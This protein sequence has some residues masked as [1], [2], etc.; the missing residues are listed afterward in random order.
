[1]TTC[2]VSTRLPVSQ[3][4][5]SSPPPA[6]RARRWPRSRRARHPRI[7]RHGQQPLGCLPGRREGGDHGRSGAQPWLADQLQRLISAGHSLDHGWVDWARARR[8]ARQ[9]LGNCATGSPLPSRSSPTPTP[10]SGSRSGGSTSPASSSPKP[11]RRSRQH[12]LSVMRRGVSGTQP[13]KPTTGPVPPVDRL[14]RQ[15]SEL[16]ERLDRMPHLT[17]RPASGSHDLMRPC[18]RPRRPWRIP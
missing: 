17:G 4:R 5:R 1:M 16:R 10:P 11:S 14:R 13:A 3:D 18:W 12:G 15:E 2:A 6:L 8:T 7:R 9:R